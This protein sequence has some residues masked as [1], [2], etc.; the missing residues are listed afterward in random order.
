MGTNGFEDE[1]LNRASYV[2]DV[3]KEFL[4]KEEGY[5]STVIE[6]M[7]YSL[8]AG[9]KRLRPVMMME[10]YKLFAGSDAD[11][12]VVHPFMAAMEMIHMIKETMNL[13]GITP[14]NRVQ[15]EHL[16]HCSKLLSL[17]LHICILSAIISH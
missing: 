9:G 12:S 16:V 11:M 3:L 15:I 5:A 7:N 17:M 13:S 10:A 1:L 2:E 14:L 8:L 6:A 4:P